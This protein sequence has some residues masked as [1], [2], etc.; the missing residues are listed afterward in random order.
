VI[1]HKLETLK[2]FT[3]FAELASDPERFKSFIE[4]LR[5]LECSIHEKCAVYDSL[6][7]TNE[8][9]TQ[10]EQEHLAKVAAFES[11]KADFFTSKERELQDLQKV[12]EDLDA[13]DEELET[14]R[15]YFLLQNEE[16]GKE[17]KWVNDAKEIL[18][19]QTRDYSR[20]IEDL[21]RAMDNVRKHGTV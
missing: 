1:S 8:Y 17:R 16:L 11:E 15:Q 6:E 10:R 5:A 7:K 21:E 13:R 18:I 3:S 19:V 2:N 12:K 20:K 9:W 4:E 14:L